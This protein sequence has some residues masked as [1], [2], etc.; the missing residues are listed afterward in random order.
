M[1]KRTFAVLTFVLLL[2]F[3][4]WPLARPHAQPLFQSVLLHV[5]TPGNPTALT[6]LADALQVTTSHPDRFTCATAAVSTATTVQA[7]GGSCAAPGAGQSLYL[8]DVHF[9][10][11]AAAGTAADSF[12]TLK[13]GTGGTCGTST[14]VVWGALT[15][16]NS[17]VVD[18]FSQPI[19]VSA[20]EELCWIMTTAGSKFV[21]VNGFI[22]P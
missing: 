20:N 18:N 7:L 1:M 10:T 14:E 12:P 22:A 5:G 11:S 13:S 3:A 6:S 15:T 9:S 19:K 17:T 21:I 16:A 8:T 2:V 4:V